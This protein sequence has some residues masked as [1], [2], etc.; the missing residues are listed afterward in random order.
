MVDSIFSGIVWID[1]VVYVLPGR[2]QNDKNENSK[3]YDQRNIGH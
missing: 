2:G 1:K 3:F